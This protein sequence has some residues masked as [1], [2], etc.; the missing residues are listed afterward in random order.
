MQ[1]SGE[2]IAGGDAS[3]LTAFGNRLGHKLTLGDLERARQGVAS[4][5]RR[6]FGNWPRERADSHIWGNLTD[7]TIE[8]FIEKR[9]ADKKSP[10]FCQEEIPIAD[11]KLMKDFEDLFLQIPCGGGQE[12]TRRSIARFGGFGNNGE[13]LGKDDWGLLA[14]EIDELAPS[15]MECAADFVHQ[16]KLFAVQEL[17][18]AESGCFSSD[19]VGAAQV[20]NDGAKPAGTGELE[21]RSPP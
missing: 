10:R 3:A 19:V 5:L 14:S 4:K 8:F 9:A 16:W 12:C 18:E 7:Q 15:A 13:Y 21:R 2:F 1:Q 20:A 6:G 11:L 17:L